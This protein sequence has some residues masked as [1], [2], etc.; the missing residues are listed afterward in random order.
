MAGV[1]RPAASPR[2]AEAALRCLAHHRNDATDGKGGR[3][4]T[5]QRRLPSPYP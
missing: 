3:P 1:V 2:G 5:T 4:S